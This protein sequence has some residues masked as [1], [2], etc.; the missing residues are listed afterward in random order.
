MT[1][2]GKNISR[3]GDQG[4]SHNVRV[5][6][7]P[8]SGPDQEEVSGT[9]LRMPVACDSASAKALRQAVP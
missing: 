9:A 7:G 6:S 5:I 2:C 1:S 4:C 8:L 3:V